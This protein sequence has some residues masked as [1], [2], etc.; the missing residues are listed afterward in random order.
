MNSSSFDLVDIRA[1]LGSLVSQQDI[2]R[3]RT[4]MHTD[5]L[6]GP[7]VEMMQAWWWSY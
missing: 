3:Y 1:P 4:I 2:R 6:R 7:H 5:F